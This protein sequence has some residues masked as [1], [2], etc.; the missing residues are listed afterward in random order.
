[1]PDRP[2]GILS[3]ALLDESDDRIDDH[4]SQNHTGVQP[5]SQQGGHR[6]RCQQ[7]IDE[8]IVELNEETQQGAGWFR[9]RHPIGTIKLQTPS[10]LSW[11]QPLF[12]AF[13]S[14]QGLVE[15]HGVPR[16]W[17]G[18]CCSAFL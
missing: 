18:G 11:H 9:L 4:D 10:D 1:M 7:D 8:Y 12:T 14:R 2:Q 16:V 6:S 15:V 5:M 3:L 13:K 17:T